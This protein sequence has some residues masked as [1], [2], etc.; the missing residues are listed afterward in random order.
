M[1]R[2]SGVDPRLDELFG[3]RDREGDAAVKP[4]A[5]GVGRGTAL[6]PQADPVVVDVLPALHPPV[7]FWRGSIA[8]HACIVLLDG[9]VVGRQRPRPAVVRGLSRHDPIDVRGEL[10]GLVGQ[11]FDVVL[12]VLA[13]RDLRGEERI[14][15]KSEANVCA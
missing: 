14:R 8:R 15:G 7:F 5:T 1:R 10:E 6:P 12:L 3:Q 4:I 2:T 13:D 9:A 11:L